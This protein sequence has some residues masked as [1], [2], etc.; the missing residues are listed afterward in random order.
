MDNLPGDE[1][2]KIYQQPHKTLES[3]IMQPTAWWRGDI[4]SLPCHA[5]GVGVWEANKQNWCVCFFFLAVSNK[6]FLTQR[7]CVFLSVYDT[8]PNPFVQGTRSR[9]RGLGSGH[10]LGGEGGTQ[11]ITVLSYQRLIRILHEKDTHPSWMWP[12][13]S[14]HYINSSPKPR[15][16]LTGSKAQVFHLNHL[17]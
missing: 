2:G 10:L 17:D 14:A 4:W 7:S 1:D 3:N 11:P 16:S 5:V 15:L 13:V 9:F 8:L 12:E 6:L